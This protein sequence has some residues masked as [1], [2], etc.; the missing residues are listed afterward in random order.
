[1]STIDDLH[2]P[3]VLAKMLAQWGLTEDL[4]KLITELSPNHG[5]TILSNS[6]CVGGN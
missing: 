1:M 5:E 6:S 4:I 3:E 2:N